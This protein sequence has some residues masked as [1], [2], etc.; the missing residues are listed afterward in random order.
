M[1]ACM[2]MQVVRGE[3]PLEPLVFVETFAVL[4]FP[5]IPCVAALAL[6][7]ESVPSLAGRMGDVLYFFLSMFLLTV[8][9]IGFGGSS[10]PGWEAWCDIGGLGF[11]HAQITRVMHASSFS[12]GVSH[13]DPSL[14][15]VIFPGMVR[16]WGLLAPRLGAALLALPLIALA[17]LCFRRFD[18]ASGAEHGKRSRFS[19]RRAWESLTALI[20]RR[21]LPRGGWA[22]GTPSFARAVGLDLRLS[23]ALMP[24]AA[25]A[26]LALAAVA[27]LVPGGSAG[28]S[29]AMFWTLVPFLAA[30]PTRD[31]SG[32]TMGLIL[33]A[34]LL[35]RH[36]VLWK[37]CSALALTLL[38]GAVPL[39]RVALESPEAAGALVNG[40]VFI[41]AAA[42][43]LGILTGT[44]KTFSVLFLLFLYLVSSSRT[45][46]ALDFA[47]WNGC[48]APAVLVYY[49]LTSLL[50]VV[51]ALGWMAWRMRRERIRN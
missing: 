46:Q 8:P 7:F 20:R 47:G 41:A 10:G 40:M 50:L 45:V 13:F 25:V 35:R 11:T 27:L 14:P 48:A 24:F 38:I 32:N 1:A 5:L 12:I 42:T 29:Q 21:L 33:T 23:L 4:F 26:A 9:A 16:D 2:G 39:A 15:P 44:P 19:A 49:A 3:G 34:P 43:C 17:V 51:A 18:P 22:G 36:F 37:F 6:L 31:R 28:V 30:V